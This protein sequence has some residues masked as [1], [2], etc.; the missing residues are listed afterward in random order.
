MPLA[1][2]QGIIEVEENGIRVSFPEPKA[3]DSPEYFAMVALNLQMAS[4][5]KV[6]VEL[7]KAMDAMAATQKDG[8][9]QQVDLAIEKVGTLFDAAGVPRPGVSA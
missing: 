8:I 1:I 6:L 4:V 5:L 3:G 9:N 7:P 2:H